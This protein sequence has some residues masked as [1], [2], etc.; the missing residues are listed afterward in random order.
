VTGPPVTLAVGPA[1]QQD[2]V[3]FGSENHGDSR[4]RAIGGFDAGGWSGGESRR[5]LRNPA[6]RG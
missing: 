6:Q 5:K 1:N 3:G 4:L 2:A